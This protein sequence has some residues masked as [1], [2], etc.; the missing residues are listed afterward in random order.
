MRRSDSNPG[1]PDR[2]P[3]CEPDNHAHSGACQHISWNFEYCT[4]NLYS[5][6]KYL[7][8]MCEQWSRILYEKTWFTATKK[9]LIW[10]VWEV[11]QEG[12]LPAYTFWIKEHSACQCGIQSRQ[13][14]AINFAANVCKLLVKSFISISNCLSLACSCQYS[15]FILFRTSFMFSSFVNYYRK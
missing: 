13:N 7:Q 10:R 8:C 1:L 15:A 14:R 6:C 2:R 9:N 11:Y 4:A 12:A 3:R 5:H